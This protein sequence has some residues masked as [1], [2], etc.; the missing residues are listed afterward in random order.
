M[1]EILHYFGT[2]CLLAS[3]LFRLLP[4]P[5]DIHSRCYSIFYDVVRRASLNLPSAP[6]VPTT[7]TNATSTK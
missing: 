5:E 1:T 4:A 7:G 6:I 3:L 2:I